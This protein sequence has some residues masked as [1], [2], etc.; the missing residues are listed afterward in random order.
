MTAYAQRLAEEGDHYF[1]SRPAAFGKS[2]FLDTLKELSVANATTLRV[3][4]LN[5]TRR[6]PPARGTSGSLP[7]Q[8]RQGRA[9]PHVM[10][11]YQR[12]PARFAAL[13]DKL[14]K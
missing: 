6:A 8:R 5:S 11:A 1:L 12:S 3:R 9:R 14:A 10:A 4:L 2:L 13:Y 7:S